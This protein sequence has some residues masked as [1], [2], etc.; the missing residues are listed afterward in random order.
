MVKAGEQFLSN[1]L[2]APF[3][4]NWNRII[5]AFPDFL[6]KLKEAVELDNEEA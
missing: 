1:P 6:E 5:S 3:I 2:E 4:P